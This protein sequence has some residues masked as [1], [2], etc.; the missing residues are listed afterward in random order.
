[1]Y[2]HVRSSGHGASKRISGYRS[3]LNSTNVSSGPAGKCVSLVTGEVI[4]PTKVVEL[5]PKKK[6][7]RKQRSVTLI[8]NGGFTQ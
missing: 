5:K 7:R 1:L 3:Y 6:K 4:K 2:K 8:F